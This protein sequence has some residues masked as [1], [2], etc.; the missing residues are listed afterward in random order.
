MSSSAN[1]N[2]TV[3]PSRDGVEKSATFCPYS[4]PIREC[5]VDRARD[6]SMLR[7]ML[8]ELLSP[9]LCSSSFFC[10]HK[11]SKNRRIRKNKILNQEFQQES[12]HSALLS[13]YLSG[14]VNTCISE[15]HHRPPRKPGHF[16][17]KTR[18]ITIIL[19]RYSQHM[20]RCRSGNHLTSVFRST[21]S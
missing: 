5:L 21:V 20:S 17:T 9:P 15:Q 16:R 18:S 12:K 3:P 6:D 11:N 2:N 8:I 19:S 1:A 7:V 14:N 4:A 13:L 10:R